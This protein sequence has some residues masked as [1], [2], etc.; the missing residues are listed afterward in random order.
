[1]T[2]R[3]PRPVPAVDLAAHH[4]V[5]YFPLGA[6]AFGGAERS[7]LELAAAQQGAGKRVLVCYER[8]LAGTDFPAQAATMG[9]PLV[10]VDW[11]PEQPLAQVARS[12]WRLLRQLDADVIHFNI[13]WRRR[14]WCVPL[15]ARLASRAK[16]VG[17]MRAMPEPLS[18]LPRRRHFGFIPGLRLWAWPDF[19]VGR[20]WAHALHATVSVNRDNYPPRLVRAFGFPRSRLS[21]IYNGVYM[22][23]A[24]PTAQD[25]LAAR[26]GFALDPHA[27]IVAFVGRVSPEKGLRYL[28][29]AV[30][31][32]A[33]PVQL[34]VAGDGSDLEPM[35][36][37]VESQNRGGRVRFLGYVSPAAA[38]FTAADVIV[39]PSLSSEAFGR[40]VVEAMACGAVVV[41]SAVGGMQ[42]IFE[43]RR[44]GLLVPKADTGAIARALDELAADS[45]WLG[46][47]A[48][49]AFAHARHTFSTERVC[50]QYSA[51]YADLVG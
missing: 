46:K 30:A 37:R 47:L 29:D 22:P 10:S 1:M 12:V 5:V 41:A 32:C 21:V 15:I 26:S 31:Q 44:Q 36:Q 35:R 11:A 20:A 45:A 48:Q 14:M 40:V 49:A 24:L 2:A 16:L 7:I 33:A 27:F 3:Q 18:D 9:L 51:L 43:H 6:A 23:A 42:E 8:A 4:D 25:R 17:T 13:S 38:V 39:V 19:I 50:S 28:I 34:V